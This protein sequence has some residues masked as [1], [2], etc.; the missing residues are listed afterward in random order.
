MLIMQ[1]IS[2]LAGD[3]VCQQCCLPKHSTSCL[4]EG[5]APFCVG[6]RATFR[7]HNCLQ[8][9]TS[10][11]MQ[12]PIICRRQ[13][14]QHSCLPTCS[15]TSLPGVECQTHTYLQAPPDASSIAS[16]SS[17]QAENGSL[18]GPTALAEVL[19][20]AAP[21]SSTASMSSAQGKSMLQVQGMAGV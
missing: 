1:E 13:V 16:V 14:C 19:S 11:Q 21:P 2:V 12:C 7:S 9:P 6:L 8:A 17:M 10:C 18:S 5:L 15:T 4:S 3:D 20:E